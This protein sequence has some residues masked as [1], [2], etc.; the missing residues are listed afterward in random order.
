MCVAETKE[1]H[2]REPQLMVAEGKN[3]EDEEATYG[4]GEGKYV[5][6]KGGSGEKGQDGRRTHA[7]AAAPDAPGS[8]G[9]GTGDD[10]GDGD[11]DGEGEGATGLSPGLEKFFAKP[12]MDYVVDF[13]DAFR[14]VRA[15]F[16]C[17]R[18][19]TAPPHTPSPLSL[20][21][22]STTPSGACARVHV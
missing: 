13:Y 19:P 18:S 8:S 10:D 12:A 7:P 6:A 14:C 1:E 9:G 11:G 20:P 15:P 17:D 3:Q 4:R 22:I 16:T 5:E 2:K 21:W